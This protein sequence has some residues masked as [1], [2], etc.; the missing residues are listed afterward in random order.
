MPEA[1][2]STQLPAKGIPPQLS[3]STNSSPAPEAA[4]SGPMPEAATST[5]LPI[6]GTDPRLS[7]GTHS[8]SVPEAALD[9]ASTQLPTEGTGT[10]TEA[11]LSSG[12]TRA[13]VDTETPADD[14]EATGE[15]AH[16]ATEP[17]VDDQL[18][19]MSLSAEAAPAR[20]PASPQA[21]LHKYDIASMLSSTFCGVASTFACLSGQS[22]PKFACL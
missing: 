16:C 19:Q 2:A 8:G 9:A 10:G 7:G 20:S 18:A 11:R 3:S 15:A 22:D 1:T 4:I 6:E 13:R 17:G 14:V 5:Q 12:S 21:R